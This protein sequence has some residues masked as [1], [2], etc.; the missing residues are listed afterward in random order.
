LYGH[1]AFKSLIFVRNDS[2][3]GDVCLRGDLA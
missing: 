1:P 3:F 2:S